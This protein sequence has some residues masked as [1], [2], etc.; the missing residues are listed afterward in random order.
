MLSFTG[1]AHAS[2]GALCLLCSGAYLVS[3]LLADPFVRTMDDR[4]CC[5]VQVHLF[6]I[7]LLGFSLQQVEFER[8][9]LEDVLG[10]YN[11]RLVL[12]S[13]V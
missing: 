12:L 10:R 6:L 1:R 8:G 9:S 7:L 5:L 2:S 3:I 13:L 11:N 4:L